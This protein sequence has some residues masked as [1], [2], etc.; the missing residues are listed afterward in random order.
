MINSFLICPKYFEKNF[1]LELICRLCSFNS[2]SL[3][4]D[5]KHIWAISNIIASSMK[6]KGMK[7]LYLLHSQGIFPRVK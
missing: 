6:E 5:N 2:F 7:K 1:K 4:S 3:Y